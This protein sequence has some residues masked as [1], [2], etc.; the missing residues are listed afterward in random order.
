[1]FLDIEYYSEKFLFTAVCE[2]PVIAYLLE[3]L[4]KDMLKKTSYEL[5][6]GHCYGTGFTGTV[7]LGIEG[8]LRIRNTH[9]TAV[10]NGYTVGITAKVI[11]GISKA[12]ES[13]LDVGAPV[14]AVQG[15]PKC[16]P[17]SGK[18]K[19]PA[20][21]GKYKDSLFVEAVQ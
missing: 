14:L 8:H 18:L 6:V 15:V 17:F 3:A 4:R 20:V 12:V 9:Y 19:V 11:N 2:Q 21:F 7:I 5:L 1:M 16:I 10:R 13:L